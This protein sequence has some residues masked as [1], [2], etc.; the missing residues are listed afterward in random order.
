MRT[1]PTSSISAANPPARESVSRWASA[2]RSTASFRCLKG[3]L[4]HRPDAILSI[5]TYKS[6]TAAAA[7]Q[8]G[9]EIVN[10]VSGFLWDEA[11]AQVCAAARCGVVLDAY[12][13]PAGGM[14]RAAAPWTRSR[15]YL[16]SGRGCSSGCSK[17]WSRESRGIESSSTPDSASASSPTRTTP[18]S[19]A[20]TNWV[21]WDSRCS[22]VSPARDFWEEP[23]LRSIREPTYRWIGE[24]TPLWQRSPLPSGRRAPGK[25]ARRASKPG[26][27]SH[28]RRHPDRGTWLTEND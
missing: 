14:A 8:A 10:D 9:A 5:D 24:A 2:K 28:S 4:R 7:L 15:S 18:Y 19:R 26:S 11:M 22:R 1:G 25:G 12:P 6:Q 27:G 13:G 16:T 3:I 23:C 21:V 20:L 17:P